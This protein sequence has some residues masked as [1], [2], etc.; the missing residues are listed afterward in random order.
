[1][2]GTLII[3]NFGCAFVLFMYIAYLFF[4][5]ISPENFVGGATPDWKYLYQLGAVNLVMWLLLFFLIFNA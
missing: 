2:M 3:I 5:N 1:M 4:E